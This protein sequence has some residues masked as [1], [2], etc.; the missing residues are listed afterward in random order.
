MELSEKTILEFIPEFKGIF[1]IDVYET[2]SS[3]NTLLKELAKQGESEGKIVI[4]REQT[5]GRGRLGRSFYSPNGTG[6]YMSLL[7]RPKITASEA[8]FIT[9]SAAVAVAEAI[10]VVSKKEAKIK[11]VNDIFCNNKKVCGILTESSLSSSGNRNDEIN[12]AVLGI[13]INVFHP[14]N[15]FN[16]NIK[17]IASSIFDEGT[18]VS[19]DIQ[20]KLIAEILRRFWFYYRDISGKSFLTEYKKRSLLIGKEISIV[21]GENIEKAI[22]LGIDDECRLKVEMMDHSVRLLSS[23]EVSVRI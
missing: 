15:G 12:Y 16:D 21:F 8:L 5:A 23:G 1:N 7:L 2:T 14:E 18:D 22:A 11:W 9:S 10:E 19:I 3:T 17:D 20:A 4:S 13:G 6:I